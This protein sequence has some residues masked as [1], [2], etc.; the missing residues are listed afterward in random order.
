M[1]RGPRGVARYSATRGFATDE[2]EG[3]A[4]YTPDD[5][6]NGAEVDSPV[7]IYDF[8]HYYMGSC[9]AEL[10]RRQGHE[11]TIVTPANAVSAW[12]FMNNERT[13]IRERMIELG[14]NIVLEHFVTGFRDGDAQLASVY[15]GVETAARQC[16]S[17]V[18]VG[19]RVPNDGLFRDLDADATRTVDSGIGEVRRIGDC[20][21]PGAI[22][23]A[24]HSGHECARTIEDGVPRSASW[25]RAAL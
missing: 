6:L 23:H 24:V 8:D 12:T 20:R 1:R 10:L 16:G 15:R 13:H 14:V 3:D 7:T 17:L 4:V 9:L 21:S 2:L 11:V 22:V 25:E 18:V 19:T 5:I